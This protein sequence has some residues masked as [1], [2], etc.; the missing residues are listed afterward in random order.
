MWTRLRRLFSSPPPAG[1]LL[2]GV[3]VQTAAR[4]AVT[5]ALSSATLA[6]AARASQ[7]SDGP[8]GPPLQPRLVTFLDSLL[9][10]F[11]ETNADALTP[12]D[13]L[14]LEGLVTRLQT[15]DLKVAMLPEVTL[16]LTEMLRHGDRPVSEYVTLINEDPSLSVELLKTANSAAY[17]AATP[18][19]S[20][21][22]AIV[23][24]GLAKLQAILMLT[25]I[26]TRVMKAGP[27][28]GQAELL[29]DMALPLA[30]LA[31]AVSRARGGPSDLAF[32]RGML[33]H[34]EHLLILG[35]VA[36]ISREHRAIISPS[37]P[38]L[39]L[40]FVRSGADVRHAAAFLWK[41]EDVLLR[42]ESDRDPLDY[43]VLRKALA[44]KWLRRPLPA[45]EGVSEERLAA[46]LADMGPRVPQRH[47]E[48]GDGNHEAAL[49][50][51]S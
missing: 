47:D 48:S 9:S 22:E 40:A 27:L 3:P 19:T 8:A 49:D 32:M 24:I 7:S 6:P 13:I 44:A 33:L 26:K 5:G 20:V 46:L 34:I 15:A 16:R 45:V 51:A 43:H 31:A 38:A 17:G 2:A 23:R 4:P 14:F 35:M 18:T 11:D 42:R 30:S 50:R 12:D 41:L 1:T 21:H 36:D 10:P 37:N 39:L 28:R 25:L 29:V